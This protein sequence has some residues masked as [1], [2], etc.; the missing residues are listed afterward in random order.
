MAIEIKELVVK[1]SV[2]DRVQKQ[3]EAKT[4][5]NLNSSEVKNII[6]YCTDEVLR[7]ISMK[8]ER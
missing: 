3:S 2:E 4:E 5:L 8:E 7:K 6:N 1:F